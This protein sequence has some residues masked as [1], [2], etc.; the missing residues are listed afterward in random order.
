MKFQKKRNI[1]K[2]NFRS[3]KKLH[4]N[5]EK[6]HWLELEKKETQIFNRLQKKM[7]NP[8]IYRNKR[9][10]EKK[11]T[12]GIRD[13]FLLVC[14]NLVYTYLLI[15][16]VFLLYI[17]ILLFAY[18]YKKKIK[19][20]WQLAHRKKKE[21]EKIQRQRFRCDPEPFVRHR[22]MAPEA[23]CQWCQWNKRP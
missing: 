12:D 4:S 22:S 2:Y 11:N 9:K 19:K 18:N 1:I 23:K 16:F 3:L 5:T 6:Y 21:E 15:I 14:F 13:R 17:Y 7:Q 8:K 20:I 10:E